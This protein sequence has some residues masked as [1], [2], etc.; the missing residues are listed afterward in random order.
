M[1]C[2]LHAIR[3]VD[4]YDVMKL[5]VWL[6]LAGIPHRLQLAHCDQMFF[7]S[8]LS[9]SCSF[10]VFLVVSIHVSGMSTS[11]SNLCCNGGGLM[12]MASFTLR[13]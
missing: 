11:M 12:W 13:V 2:L 6:R 8:P 5:S 10:F 7:Q 1:L 4:M 9:Q 3:L